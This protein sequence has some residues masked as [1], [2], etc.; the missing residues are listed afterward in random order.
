MI[1]KLKTLMLAFA[2]VLALSAPAMAEE[3]R[4]PAA[5]TNIAMAVVDIQQLLRES[6]AAQ[7]IETQLTGIRKKFQADV[8]AKEKELRAAEKKLMEEKGNLKEEELKAKV[9]EFQKKVT[10]TQKSIQTEK[11]KLDKAV[12]AAIGKLRAQIVKVVAEI[13]DKKNLDLVLART[14]VVI[15]SKTLDITSEVLE[16]INKDLPSVTVVVE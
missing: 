8:E 14:D 1:T 11:N 6:K 2:A 13:A 12:A 15:V 4:A 5:N 10:D 16:R 9:Q 7:G 3:T